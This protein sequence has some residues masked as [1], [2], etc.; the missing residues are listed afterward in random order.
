MVTMTRQKVRIGEL[1][2]SEGVITHEQWNTAIEKQRDDG[3][4]LGNILVELGYVR[5]QDMLDFLAKQL[6]IDYVDLITL[7][8]AT[9]FNSSTSRNLCAQISCNFV[10]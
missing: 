3:G 4:R 2:I 8:L 7:S 5:E 9:R 6:Q 10:E 1:L